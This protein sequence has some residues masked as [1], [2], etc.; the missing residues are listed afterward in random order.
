VKLTVL[1]SGS[2]GNA[3]AIVADGR[4]LLIDA[5]FGP[6]SLARRAKSVGIRL[7]TLDGVLLTHEHGDHARG[8]AALARYLGCPVYASPG[9]LRSLGPRLA[10]VTT[11]PIRPEYDTV[12]I[13]PFQV[14]AARTSH[15]AAEPLAVAIDAA[16]RRVGI[17]YDLG[18]PTRA[19]RD[20]LRDC[21]CLVVETNHDEAMLAA[22]PYPL[23]VQR[24]IAGVGG[25]LSNRAAANLVHEL[26]H[27]ALETVVLAH[28]SD[29]CN[30][31]ALAEAAVSSMLRRC[32]FRGRVVVALQWTPLAP[33]EVGGGAQ[34]RLL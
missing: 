18:V 12:V 29:R 4:T 28:L 31:P 24:R 13:G 9:T 5:G 21:G 23:A 10:G 32:R 22:G 17:A 7:R 8:A 34:M 27:D 3:I 26:Y 14:A 19:V 20:L 25:H 11:R 6:R 2:R 16:G 33:M 15:D 1:G 30:T